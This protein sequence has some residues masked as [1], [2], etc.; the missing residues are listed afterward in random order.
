[1]AYLVGAITGAKEGFIPVTDSRLSLA[2]LG[3]SASNSK[4]R[5]RQLRF[6]AIQALPAPSLPPPVGEIAAFK[7]RH[8][9]DLRRLRSHLDTKLADLAMIEDEQIRQ[10]KFSGLVQEIQDEVMYLRQQMKQR[11]WPKVAL[12]GLG[13]VIGAGLTTATALVTGGSALLVG[14]AVG[15]GLTTGGGA[16]YQL[17]EILRSPRLARRSPLAYAALG[18]TL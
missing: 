6:A 10:V 2:A 11:N 5:L 14:L 4:E 18:Q 3:P 16:A 7:E 12:V 8:G 17:T 15:S 13:G 9:D 1:M